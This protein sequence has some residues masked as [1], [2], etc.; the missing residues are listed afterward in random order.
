M[1]ESTP[2]LAPLDAARRNL[3]AAIRMLF[4]GEDPI[5]VHLVVAATFRVLHGLAPTRPGEPWND[6]LKAFLLPGGEGPFFRA[7]ENAAT[8]AAHVDRDPGAML[9]EVAQ[10]RNDFEIAIACLYLECL[11][12]THSPEAQAFL[13]WFATMYPHV[14]KAD[15]FFKADLPTEDFQ[16]LK[17]APRAKQLQFGD[18]VLRLVWRNRLTAQP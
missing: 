2:P 12:A 17:T 15:R 7:L 14:M 3:D 11:G 8:F 4:L 1:H 16:W 10:E 18:T 6:R 13:W 9:Q 5:P